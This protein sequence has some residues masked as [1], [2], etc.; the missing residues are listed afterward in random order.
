MKINGIEITGFVHPAVRSAV[1]DECLKLGISKTEQNEN[2]YVWDGPKL[3]P[4]SVKIIS[5]TIENGVVFRVVLADGREE[6]HSIPTAWCAEL[7]RQ[8]F[9]G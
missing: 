9:I 4:G 2:G 3:L 1:A 7:E 6:L 8:G 5:E